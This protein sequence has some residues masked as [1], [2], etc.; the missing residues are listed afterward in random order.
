MNHLTSQR[1]TYLRELHKAYA[2]LQEVYKVLARFN[3]SSTVGCQ[4]I[5]P[6]KMLEK[7]PHAIDSA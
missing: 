1:D 7:R 4:V 5:Y 2:F 6:T 3:L